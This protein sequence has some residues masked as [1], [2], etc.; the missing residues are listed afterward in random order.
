[1][2]GAIENKNAASSPGA[3]VFDRACQ[4]SPAKPGGQIDAG[5]RWCFVL[6]VAFVV[7]SG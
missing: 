7:S 6:L 5:N 4:A 2:A 3:L 1:L